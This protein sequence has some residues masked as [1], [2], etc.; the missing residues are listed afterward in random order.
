MTHSDVGAHS[1]AGPLRPVNFEQSNEPP[2]KSDS[3]EPEEMRPSSLVPSPLLGAD[4]T[5]MATDVGLM[6]LPSGYMEP[7]QSPGGTA[8]GYCP[9]ESTVIKQH[10]RWKDRLRC[11]LA[12]ADV[13]TLLMLGAPAPAPGMSPDRV[14][15]V[16]APRGCFARLAWRHCAIPIAA[17]RAHPAP[18]W[19][20]SPRRTCGSI[21]GPPD[22]PQACHAYDSKANRAAQRARTVSDQGVAGENNEADPPCAPETCAA[23]RGRA[24]CAGGM[25]EF[26]CRWHCA[27]SCP[28][29]T[30][31]QPGHCRRHHVCHCM[32]R[33]A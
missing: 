11:A 6:E 26:E 17:L 25:I 18:C 27:N 33:D 23:S 9:I 30:M 15:I 7:A 19:T 28:I 32:N 8:D 31:L 14:V 2:C 3:A 29:H 4:L 16:R 10:K 12:H 1:A 13:D 21:C 20:V 5:A 22:H 24:D